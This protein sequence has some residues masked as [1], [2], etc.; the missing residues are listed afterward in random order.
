MSAQ[1]SNL[2]I[3]LDDPEPGST[4]FLSLASIV[5]L[6]ALV[7]AASVMYFHVETIEHDEK[8]VD[9]SFEKLE[10]TR[11]EWRDQLSR[12]QR[13]Q[14]IQPDGKQVQKVRIPIERA[15]ELT[16]QQGIEVSQMPATP[17]TPAP[18][19]PSAKPA[20]SA[21]GGIKK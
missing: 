19:T 2:S 15:M 20:T 14:W 21:P 12:Y 3:Q 6:V 18:P 7:V 9:Q 13:Y 11:S 17:A 10:A 8:V 16:A 5:I 1:P 4:W